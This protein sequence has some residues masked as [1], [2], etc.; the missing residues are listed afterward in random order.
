[1]SNFYTLIMRILAHSQFEIMELSHNYYSLNAPL[2]KGGM[3]SL[4]IGQKGED[5]IFSLKR[6]GIKKGV[7][8]CI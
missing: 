3:D 1:M 6:G 5:L 4:K 7:I 2:F 8:W